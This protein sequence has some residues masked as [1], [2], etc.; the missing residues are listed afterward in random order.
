MNPQNTDFTE[1][2]TRI[3]VDVNKTIWQDFRRMV[4]NTKG[5]VNG[6]LSYEVN[7]A[8]DTYL[9]IIDGELILQDPHT[10]D[11]GCDYVPQECSQEDYVGT[12][13]ERYRGVDSIHARQL[14]KFV[15]DVYGYTSRLKYYD[16]RDQLLAAGVLYP[17]DKRKQVFSIHDDALDFDAEEETK[18]V[19][20]EAK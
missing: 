10:L 11:E 4:K 5:K 20:G 8:L 16:I 1:E 19:I 12:F 7:Q 14:R 9:K 13:K 6:L 15:V 17:E 2:T 18:K 3:G